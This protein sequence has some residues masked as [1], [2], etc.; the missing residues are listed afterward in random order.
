MFEII[1]VICYGV[2]G[3]GVGGIIFKG[4]DAKGINKLFSSF[5]INKEDEISQ[6]KESKEK[7]K[8]QVQKLTKENTELQKQYNRALRNI[9]LLQMENNKAQIVIEDT[10]IDEGMDELLKL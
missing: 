6:I 3:F 9:E 1:S 8:F 10:T 7:D 2:I 5:R 4:K